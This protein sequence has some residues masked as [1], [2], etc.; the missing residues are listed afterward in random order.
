VSRFNRTSLI[1]I[2]AS[3]AIGALIALAGSQ[4]SATV[5]GFPVF[6]LCAVIAFAIQFVVFVPSYLART[7]HYYDITG[8]V[9]YLTVTAV[10]LLTSNDLDARAVIVAILVAVWAGRLGTF[11][12]RRVK[13]DGGDGR[14]DKIKHNPLRFFMMWSIQGLWVFLTVAC[15]LSIIT[16][17]ERKSFD[18]LAA[19]GLLVWLAGFAIEV[20]ADNQKSAFR[21]DP[22][23]RGRFINVGLWA[24]SRHPNYFG[25][26]VLWTGVAIIA[27]PILSGWRWVMLISPVFVFVLL[28][29]ISGV[30]LLEARSDK[31]WGEE[32]EYQEYKRRTPTLVPR[33]PRSA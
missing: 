19:I 21:A 23:N 20:A 17:A 10:A 32:A 29:R 33:P 14:F 31:R 15:A 22:A 12:F 5:G 27:I 18:V 1:G 9:T 2:I 16:G 6:A 28:T 4:G 13:R 24:W 11:L 25:E 7:E 3:L 8:S 26:I 30:P